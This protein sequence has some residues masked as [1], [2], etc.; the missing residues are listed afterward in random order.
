VLLGVLPDVQGMNVLVFHKSALASTMQKIVKEGEYY[1]KQRK[2][3]GD[4]QSSHDLL[5]YEAEEAAELAKK[6]AEAAA[7]EALRLENIKKEEESLASAAS[8]ALDPKEVKRL[9]QLKYAEQR[10]KDNRLRQQQSRQRKLLYDL[11]QSDQISQIFDA[12]ASQADNSA[13][14]TWDGEHNKELQAKQDEFHRIAEEMA[15]HHYETTAPS[16][17]KKK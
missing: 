9:T 11:I 8:I 10:R 3:T 7:A 5:S 13:P 6:E 4:G 14:P 12:K 16:P 1:L 2:R 17:S 15:S